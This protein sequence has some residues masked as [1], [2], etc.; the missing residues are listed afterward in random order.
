MRSKDNRRRRGGY[1]LVEV[2]TVV[3][4]I[5]IL[6][7]IAIPSVITYRRSLK[8]TELDDN[9][10]TIYLAAQSNLT[11]L[12][13]ASGE[14]LELGSTVGRPA[15][16]VP[17]GAV[18]GLDSSTKL[19]YVS[20]N[21]DS[22]DPDWL[23]IPGS[24]DSALRE[25][26]SYYLVE[27]DPASGVVY[28][29]FYS[30]TKSGTRGAALN[31]SN[32]KTL[33]ENSCRTRSGRNAF[34]TASGGFWV[35]YYGADGELDLSR[36]E[37]KK[38]P[39]PKLKLTNAE[40]LVL[41]LTATMDPDSTVNKN[42]VFYTV[43]LSDGAH[44]ATLV[45]AGRF[46]DGAT[47][48]VVLDTLRT[49]Y[50][51]DP[52]NPAYGGW[53]V[54]SSFAGWGTG[55]TP[56]ADVT[57]TVSVWYQPASDEGLSAL[58]QS[59]S[60]KTNSLFAARSEGTVQV[61]YGRHLQNLGLTGLDSSITAA[62]QVRDV[63]F[64]KT[65]P[66]NDKDKRQHWAE[67][68]G[69]KT[70]VPVE[71]AALDRFDGQGR[72]IKNLNATA[73]SGKN[74][75]LFETLDAATVEGVTLV[76]AKASATG[77]SAGALAGVAKN[78]TQV[79]DCQVYLTATGGVYSAATRIS[80]TNA[81]GLIG[82]AQ[83]CAVENSFASTVV[84]G[85][86]NTGGLVGRSSNVNIKTSY[87]AGR[88]SGPRVGGLVGG[89]SGVTMTDCYAAGLLIPDANG[90]AAGLCAEEVNNATRCYAAA[91][92]TTQTGTSYSIK[93]AVPGGNCNSVY[94]LAK[95]GV[96][97]AATVAGVDRVA[98]SD[99]MKKGEGGVLTAFYA[100]KTSTAKAYPYNHVTRTE[101]EGPLKSPY[102]YPTLGDLPH[103][104]DWLEATAPNVTSLV[105]YYEQFLSNSGYV[106]EYSYFLNGAEAGTLDL[107][108]TEAI[109]ADGYAFLSTQRLHND[110]ENAATL[111]VKSV[112]TKTVEDTVSAYFVGALDEEL[113]PT[114]G[115]AAYYAYAIPSAALNVLSVNYYNE[116]TVQ[117][118]SQIVNQP[119]VDVAATAWVNPFFGRSA[120]NGAKPTST[121]AQIHIRS[122]RQ[123]ANMSRFFDVSGSGYIQDLDVDASI[124]CG[125]V[126]RDGKGGDLTWV[127]R[128]TNAAGHVT[129]A[130]F[131]LWGRNWDGSWGYQNNQ[132]SLPSEYRLLFT[133]IGQHDSEDYSKV[134]SF[135]SVYDGNGR[136]IRALSIRDYSPSSSEANYAGLFY[137]VTGTLKNITMVDCDVVGAAGAESNSTG[138]LAGRLNSKG[139]MLNCAVKDCTVT[140]QG[141]KAGGNM[142]GMV[143]Y[144]SDGAVVVDNCTV[145]NC[146]VDGGAYIQNAGG[147][148]GYVYNLKSDGVIRD[149]TVTNVQTSV[150]NSNPGG[151]SENK[152]GAAG[153]FVG[154]LRGSAGALDR[155]TVIGTR[156]F[157]VS[158][159]S[160]HSG[161]FA[162]IIS[163]A[164]VQ[165]CGVRLE[166]NAKSGY[167]AQAVSGGQFTGGFVGTLG[168][169]SI[170]SSYAAV[171]A[172]GGT[173]G[174]FAGAI[175][176]GSVSNCYAG[177][178]TKSGKYSVSQ[179]NVTGTVQAGGLVGLW[180]GGS[181]D[182]CYTTCSVSGPNDGATDVFANQETA[183][184]TSPVSGCYA[185]GEAFVSG[186]KRGNLTKT[187]V[188]TSMPKLDVAQRTETHPYDTALTTYPYAP[189]KYADGALV[190]H[191]GDWPEEV[192]SGGANRDWVQ[193]INDPPDKTYSNFEI[194]TDW[195]GD[196]LH[197]SFDV[198]ALAG[199]QNAGNT[200][201]NTNGV[202]AITT[203]LGYK[204]IFRIIA[205]GDG[206]Y[207]ID[208][209]DGCTWTSQETAPLGSS[210]RHIILDFDIPT[211][212]LP[213]YK[214][215]IWV[216]AMEDE[217]ITDP[218]KNTDPGNKGVE[219][220]PLDDSIEID[221][222]FSDWLGYEHQVMEGIPGGEQTPLHGHWTGSILGY[223]NKIYL[224][225]ITEDKS[226]IFAATLSGLG[227]FKID[228]QAE[229]VNLQTER[230]LWALGNNPYPDPVPGTKEYI[231]AQE[232]GI[233]GAQL[234]ER[235]EIIHC[236]FFA[237]EDRQE[238][239]MEI[240]LDALAKYL[241]LESGNVFTNFKVTCGD[242]QRVLEV[243]RDP[244]EAN[245]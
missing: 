144:I 103:Y 155:C 227:I 32:Y 88:L 185:V 63:D 42:K 117:A 45:E 12:R 234:E 181:L 146:T 164:T 20:T 170:Q 11:A 70:F 47:N 217:H 231:L 61:G 140:A 10:R 168:A 157:G 86:Q 209:I 130:G 177:G 187:S 83:N 208:G 214:D 111:T 59:A 165:N 76:D 158:G 121:P 17:D 82:L 34:A 8:L 194:S 212:Q 94:Y 195:A 68:Y 108:R 49:G 16:D 66:A 39:T 193:Q 114:D 238:Y 160:Q 85:T 97:D 79:K 188:A 153:G 240:D 197:V 44:A 77:Q 87:A 41:E 90:E 205:N 27:F 229:G 43:S 15:A 102:P 14:E 6:A 174:G 199:E 104:G 132:W 161:G 28:G 171:K 182:N 55:V 151:K 105:A 1:S 33:C 196:T 207:T 201:P 64:A 225:M 106:T 167:I 141:T 100:F 3:A 62:V 109:N 24:V 142:G 189:V 113:N 131:E 67:T 107:S 173:A 166:G 21:V 120:Y 57:V 202:Y 19:K 122:L 150:S 4:L 176:G 36:P 52:G 89:G 73:Q 38:L 224:H 159:S 172:D 91:D 2:L 239:E 110:W 71:N 116:V 190:P 175:S 51:K 5:G 204:L 226:D 53:S 35:G 60:V 215:T 58:P 96:N 23:V 223:K 25:E 98:S 7:A 206:S 138:V 200:G 50:S 124:Y 84:H 154:C 180:K 92:Y 148:V 74:A 30:E 115:E 134:S 136:T 46:N 37:A 237:S 31:V 241:E 128:A 78:N 211:D 129:V 222:D 162:G 123:L 18:S 118:T 245:N 137:R 178:N 13:S 93:G 210:S 228:F 9:A 163:N 221:G 147:F 152:Q 243:Q 236:I 145:E 219:G 81:G 213:P 183:T 112:G 29:V 149:C 192:S 22:A 216:G 203:D 191:Y 69:D 230:W 169:G 184:M 143:G 232:W 101:E 99:Q 56:G 75:G 179:P 125:D 186:G 80:A 233:N 133:P 126:C 135:G 235:Q 26:D 48:T 65:T 242:S 72:A 156:D 127:G 139:Q 244:P 54:G 95:S 198:K 119:S 40:E 218:I 220:K